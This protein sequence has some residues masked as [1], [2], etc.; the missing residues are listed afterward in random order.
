MMPEWYQEK[1]LGEYENIYVVAATEKVQPK[2]TA[3]GGG[4]TALL[5]YLIDNNMIDGAATSARD[6]EGLGGRI[7][8]ARTR[9]EIIRTAGNEWQVLPFTNKLMETIENEDL[10]K[11]AV[12]GLPCQIHFIRQMKTFP[13][14]ESNFGNRVQFLIS[15]FCYGTFAH[16]SILN[17]IKEKHGMD[18]SSIKEIKVSQKSV[19]F[20]G[21][22]TLEIPF[23]ELSKYIH[24]G[25]LMCP[26]YT[27]A[28]SDIS[29][30]NIGGKTIMIVRNK[31]SEEIL[32]E[33]EGS[34]Y[35]ST[36]KC[37]E[38][39]VKKIEERAVE[40][41]KRASEYIPRLL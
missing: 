27:G 4:I 30:G 6:V 17:Y 36:S 31:M 3:A 8:V 34:G 9:E 7:V 41:I 21:E 16:E 38:E 5:C 2:R 15:L 23:G 28:F 32:R 10:K 24:M 22:K 12:V 25:C 29:A 37:D 14:V 18:I 13:L 33:A 35:I 19:K 26:D 11:V 40:K 39:T 1:P 20:M